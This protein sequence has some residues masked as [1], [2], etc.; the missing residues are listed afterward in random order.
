VQVLH[1]VFFKLDTSIWCKILLCRLVFDQSFLSSLVQGQPSSSF[2][3]CP[4]SRFVL[5]VLDIYKGWPRSRV[6]F[7]RK[8]NYHSVS[9]DRIQF[10]DIL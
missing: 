1:D 4:G 3:S 10:D 6:Q 8:W 7:C 9:V 5:L 2:I